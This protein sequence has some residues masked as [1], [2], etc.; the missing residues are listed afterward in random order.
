MPE[1]GTAEAWTGPNAGLPEQLPVPPTPAALSR[2]RRLGEGRRVR[3]GGVPRGPQRGDGWRMTAADERLLMAATRF[4]AMTWRQ[5]SAQFYGGK[6]RNSVY[7]IGYLRESG[8]LRQSRSD[9]WAGRVL[10][11]SAAGTTLIRDDLSVPIA[12]PQQ[13]PGERLLHRLAVTDCGFRFEGRGDRVITEREL[14]TSE[15]RAGLARQVA[16]SLDID[17]LR[18]VRDGRG[19][20]RWFCAPIGPS[21]SVHYP[22]LVLP[23]EDGL[24]AVEVEVTNKPAHRLREILRGFRDAGIFRQ[25]IYFATAPVAMLLHGYRDPEGGWAPGVL[26][27]LHLLPDGPPEYGPDSKVR[28]QPL[29]A[30]DEGVAYRLDMRQVPDT[31]WVEKS[32]WRDLRAAW[33]EDAEMGRPVKVPFLRWWRDV[34]VPRRRLAP[35]G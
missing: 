22:D 6:E 4:G 16:A 1:K 30:R 34:E 24:V 12:A 2:Q 19:I 15:A 9:E 32:E 14:R 3:A 23:T 20:D 21:G 27:Q 5:A 7:R 25:V 18:S 8:L 29:A 11:P 13:H 35:V 31:W 17:G 28:V 10:M 26:Q 33:A